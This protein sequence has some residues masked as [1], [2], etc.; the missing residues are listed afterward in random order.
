M[1]EAS[2]L[3]RMIIY[4]GDANIDLLDNN[5]NVTKEYEKACQS[6]E[7]NHEIRTPNAEWYLPRPHYDKGDYSQWS[8]NQRQLHFGLQAHPNEGGKESK[9]TLQLTKQILSDAALKSFFF[10]PLAFVDMERDISITREELKFVQA[11]AF[12]TIT[13]KI[14]PKNTWY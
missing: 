2:D 1:Q 8:Q 3:S 6:L 7:L 14:N 13:R 5:A 4:L 10:T 9:Q 11:E 12:Q